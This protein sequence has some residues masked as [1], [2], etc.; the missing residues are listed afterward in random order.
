M[1]EILNY[2]V[3]ALQTR[4]RQVSLDDDKQRDLDIRANLERMFQLVD[5]VTSFGNSDVKLIVTPE[6]AI[7]ARFRRM[8][9]AEWCRIA[10]TIPGPY[11]DLVCAKAKERKV[12]FAANMLEV[13]P[14][15]PRRFFNCSFLA[16]PE[17][18][19]VLKHWKNNNNAWVFP[20]TQPVDIHDEFVRRFGREAIFPVARTE[21]GGIGLL[22]CGELGFPEN[23]RCTMMNGA[24][25]LLHLTSEPNN[26]S[27]GDVRN[28]ECMRATRAYENKCYLAA[29]N[30]GIY[31]GALRGMHDSHGDSAIHTFD[32]S[33]TNKINGPGEATIKGPI[34]LNALRKAR[35]RPF[36]PTTLAYEIFAEEYRR[37]VGWRNNMFLEKPIESIE[38][39]RAKFRE[40]VEERRKRGIDKAPRDYAPE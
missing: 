26:M 8:E 2:E 27:H 30:V 25:V 20:Y 10:T 32:G 5:Y 33:I 11:S 34:D 7:N 39:T 22:T 38:Q 40:I 16:S 35:S 14:D 18:K 21:I 4:T 9:V 29:A 31:E 12:F 6:Y 3:A 13:H 19:I 28:W 15:F 1:A 36:H 17:G 37:T 24:E 23:A